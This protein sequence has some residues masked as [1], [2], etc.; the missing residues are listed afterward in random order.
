MSW[1]AFTY[2]LALKTNQVI[3]VAEY[4][5]PLLPPEVF[6]YLK[7][8]RNTTM[9]ITRVSKEAIE[10]AKLGYDDEL[11][12]SLNSPPFV[13][14]MKIERHVCSHKKTCSS[15]DSTS[16]TLKKS[17]GQI[18]AFPECFEYE[19]TDDLEKEIMSQL[20]THWSDNRYVILSED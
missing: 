13:V 18:P 15:F 12:R 16:C 19:A 11:L 6:K 8:K 14:L 1:Q 4:Y 7:E 17:Q 3:D 20:V 9:K 2:R 10:A 5:A